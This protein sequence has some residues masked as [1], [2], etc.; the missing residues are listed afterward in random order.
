MEAILFKGGGGSPCLLGYGHLLKI[1]IHDD[2]CPHCLNLP[3]FYPFFFL[4]HLLMDTKI[5]TSQVYLQ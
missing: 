1:E 2:V 3:Q 4:L 5:V